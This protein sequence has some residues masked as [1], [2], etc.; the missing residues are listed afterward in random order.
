MPTI[1]ESNAVPALRRL[2]GMPHNALD[3][4]SGLSSNSEFTWVF[5]FLG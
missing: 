4:D 3:V 2:K 1:V 5:K